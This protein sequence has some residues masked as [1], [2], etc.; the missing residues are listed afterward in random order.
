M[1]NSQRRPFV[2][3]RRGDQHLGLRHNSK[4]PIRDREPKKAGQIGLPLEGRRVMARIEI[5]EM[6]P[7]K[8]TEPCP[9][10][11]EHPYGI[12]C[13]RLDGPPLVKVPP[14]LPEGAETGY[15]HLNCYL[16]HTRNCSR[17]LSREH[18]ISAAV[19]RSI[20]GGLVVSGAPWLPLGASK[21]MYAETLTSRILCERHK[22]C[23]RSTK[24]QE[25]CSPL[26]PQSTRSSVRHQFQTTLRGTC[27]V[28]KC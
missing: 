22:L 27:A 16:G 11:G 15:S 7:W 26:C 10:G 18:Y 1:R 2:N 5:A 25:G 14:L 4:L 20:P 3:V 6:P 8:P 19:L 17:K 23:P 13:M 24:K 28:E 21:E 12:C 9:C